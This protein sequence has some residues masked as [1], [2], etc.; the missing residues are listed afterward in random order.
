M[1]QRIS[2]TEVA[3][4]LGDVLERVRYRGGSFV[5]ERNGSAMAR[6]VPCLRSQWRPFGRRSP[7]GGQPDARSKPSERH[8]RR[9][10]TPINR[11]TIRGLVMDTSALAAVERA[12]GSWDDALA[13]LG[14]EPAVLPAIVYAELLV[15]VHLAQG[16]ARARG[17]RAK[18]HTL[19]STLP[20]V[21]FTVE[22]ADVVGPRDE[23][24]FRAVPGLRVE[25]LR[26]E[27]RPLA[28][29]FARTSEPGTRAFWRRPDQEDLVGSHVER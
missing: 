2:A 16:P 24:H 4:R 12:A 18:I 14:D 22:V 19:R 27:C 29:H 23:R 1:E 9:S 17:H 28:W 15:S 8:S 7:P 25:V 21:D 3:R 20:I 5:I 10:E 26:F 11:Q 6:L 13:S